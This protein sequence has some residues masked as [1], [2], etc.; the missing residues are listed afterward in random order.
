M[1]V[2]RVDEEVFKELQK[3]AQAF[4]DT[5]NSVLRRVLGLNGSAVE[6]DLPRARPALSLAGARV[7]S[8]RG[9]TIHERIAQD[10]ASEAEY[11]LPI[12]RAL[13]RMGGPVPRDVVLERVEQTMAGGLTRA[14]YQTLAGGDIRWRKMAEWERHKMLR[15][16]LL[17][18][19]S[20]RGMWEITEEGRR[21]LA[22]HG[23][24]A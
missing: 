18:P 16:G 17:R 22:E 23:G 13:E 11:R 4:V 12:L 1:P 10:Y 9:S 8:R 2:I 24:P 6:G 20:P 3:R 14:D 19:D 5:P 21:Y 7:L 15:D